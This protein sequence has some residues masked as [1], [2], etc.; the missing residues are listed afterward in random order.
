MRAGLFFGVVFS[1][2]ASS[3]NNNKPLLKLVPSTESGIDFQNLLSVTD[4][5]NVLKYEYFYNGASVSVGDFNND[6][7]S[8][9]FFTGNLVPNRLYLNRGGLKFED[10][11]E[12][13]G[14]MNTG[15]WSTGSA[16]A[17]VNND[18]LPDIYV[19][20][21]GNSDST[22]RANS[23]FINTG[24]NKQGI[25]VFTDQAKDYGVEVF[26]F[27]QNAA[28]L[29]YDKDGDL[30][31]YI[32][33]NY[34]GIEG[35]AGYHPKI[36]DGSADNN[37]QLYRNNGDNTFTN[38]TIE[39][40]I[41]YEGYGLGLAISDINLDGYP[42]IYIGNDYVTNDLIYINN[43]DGTFS[44]KAKYMLKHQAR[45][46]MG[47]DIA[48]VNNDGL[49]DIF[50]LD[51]LPSTNYR[52]KT[53]IDGGAS[54]QTYTSTEKLGY[55]YQYMRNMMQ[56]NN[57]DGSF[58]EI[59]QMLGLYQTEWSWSPLFF[60]IDNDGFKDLLITTGF[61]KDLTNIDY[62]RFKNDVGMF[63]KSNQM[64]GVIPELKLP[65]YGF[66][67]NGD[68]TFTDKSSQWGLSTPSYSNGAAFADLDNDGD[69]D[70]IVSNINDKVHLYENT[71]YS[72]RVKKSDPHYLRIRLNGK[73]K[74]GELGTKITLYSDDG[75]KQFCDYSV[76]RGYLSTMENF[77]HFGLGKSTSVSKLEIVWPDG[78]AQVLN[79]LKA[80]QVLEINYNDS[81]P[82]VHTTDS[83][84][85]AN[86]PKYF[87]KITSETGIS[88]K[89]PEMDQIDYYLQRTLPHKFSQA[90]PGSG[91]RRY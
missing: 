32:L 2:F 69:L 6:G 50:T 42:D 23:L 27:S 28:F 77:V 51:M 5:L 90:G 73:F 70:Y 47:N 33:V 14:I 10:V 31:L 30:D 81:K 91:C 15:R 88:Y 16:V 62:V 52:K 41:V 22:K 19:C 26:G 83:L 37:D 84:N 13:A 65:N 74:G 71:L 60:D 36:V 63:T 7:L 58:S 68:L 76:Y 75:E 12:I 56:L 72:G 45:F 53:S 54:Y 86:E 49:I 4:S 85:K 20:T 18:G 82:L 79:N 61:P 1:L 78:N 17:D 8:D 59:G 34:V 9:L 67:N 44:N 55:E 3:C 89:H 39:A 46:S 64:L 87:R 38:V 25:P 66:K 43:Q 40:G 48:D 57:G 21:N 35:P 11:S 29:D 80:D 24:Q